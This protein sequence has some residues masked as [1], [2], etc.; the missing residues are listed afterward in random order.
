MDGWIAKSDPLA[1]WEQVSS[2]LGNSGTVV[3]WKNMRPPQNMPAARDLDPYSYEIMLLE[4]HL[5]LVF[6][7]F[8]EGKAAGRKKITISINGNRVEPN[9]PVGHPLTS[10]YDAKSVRIPTE[11]EY[12]R[13]EIG[14]ASWRE[15][16]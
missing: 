16:V 14:R 12:G 9:N 11:T 1:P 7:R 3:L 15:R 6:H 13:V 8:L 10:A 4:R 2:T 5:A